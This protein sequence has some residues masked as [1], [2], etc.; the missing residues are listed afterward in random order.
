VT[1]LY[2]RQAPTGGLATDDFH[3]PYLELVHLLTQA[4]GLEHS[5]LLAYLYGAF[6]LK[7]QYVNVRGTV[8]PELYGLHRLNTHQ[9]RDIRH[10]HTVLGVAVEEMQH[11]ATVNRFLR[12]LG[13][14]PVLTP[15]TF[16]FAA[17]IYPFAIDLRPLTRASV[18]TFLW[19]EAEALKFAG[20]EP[21]AEP[22]AF[23]ELVE[24]ALDEYRDPIDTEPQSHLGSLYHAI[25]RVAARVG[26]DPPSFVS[27]L[28]DWPAWL[29]QLD[30]ILGQGEIA[31]YR[32][33]RRLFTGEAFLPDSGHPGVV[34]AD[35][36]GSLYPSVALER[37]SGWAHVKDRIRDETAR[38]LAWLGDLHYWLILGLLDRSYRSMD[39]TGRY[40]GVAQMT[41]CLVAIGLELSERYHVGFPFDPLGPS[42]E[43]GADQSFAL[44]SLIKLAS[45][46]DVVAGE[47]AADDV[48][49]A[50]YDRTTVAALISP[51]RSPAGGTKD[52]R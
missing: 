39:R 2:L 4:A 46:I 42:Y 19:I 23:Q 15:H 20:N 9:D 37:G 34:W 48:L 44:D 13:A 22:P 10:I 8:A 38:R 29:S 24:E 31:H 36:N 43:F 47:L 6:S 25:G 12:V 21:G 14:P 16:P 5:L 17:D 35:P 41:Q 30:A 1:T 7:P 26:Q 11:L 3:D 52:P 51:L 40:Q 27:P 33:F 45:E 50:T 32:F 28:V 49:P 18:A